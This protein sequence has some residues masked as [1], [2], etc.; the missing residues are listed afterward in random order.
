[1]VDIAEK[2]IS[3]LDQEL[4]EVWKKNAVKLVDALD[5]GFKKLDFG[6]TPLEEIKK[7]Q[8]LINQVNTPK[9]K[10]NRENLLK[11]IREINKALTELQQNK[12]L[13][14]VQ[15]NNFLFQAMHAFKS[16]SHANRLNL[17]LINDYL[18]YAQ[19]FINPADKPGEL[20]GDLGFIPDFVIKKGAKFG[21]KQIEEIFDTHVGSFLVHQ[22]DSMPRVKIEVILDKPKQISPSF[23][24]NQLGKEQYALLQEKRKISEAK[25]V[26]EF[27]TE[28]IYGFAFEL[29]YSQV[30]TY[31]DT[32]HYIEQ[33]AN[34]QKPP[35]MIAAK[36]TALL[37]HYGIEAIST[38]EGKKF[39][40]D[41]SK[42][43]GF[44]SAE[45]LYKNY[46]ELSDENNQSAFD[47]LTEAKK[48]F[49]DLGLQPEL[50]R[51][52][53]PINLIK[54][55]YETEY[56]RIQKNKKNNTFYSNNATY[57]AGINYMVTDFAMA[58]DGV[59]KV[60]NIGAI[61]LK[62]EIAPKFGA[63]EEQGYLAGFAVGVAKYML[64]NDYID[65]NARLGLNG[66]GVILEQRVGDPRKQAKEELFNLMVEKNLKKRSI[67]EKELNNFLIKRTPSDQLVEFYFQKISDPDP[68][69]EVYKD[70]YEA[71]FTMKAL[72]N[73]QGKS[74]LALKNESKN[75][76]T[77]LSKLNEMK[78]DHQKEQEK[79]E[80]QKKAFLKKEGSFW[81]KITRVIDVV[82][83]F[84][85][86]Q[87]KSSKNRKEQEL[88]FK[89]QEE[90][91]KLSAKEL[92]LRIEALEKIENITEKQSEI[93]NKATLESPDDILK[94][95]E[96][97]VEQ[98]KNLLDVYEHRYEVASDS[99]KDLN[100]LKHDF[101]VNAFVKHDF[102]YLD[103]K[104]DFQEKY[105]AL[106]NDILLNKQVILNTKSKYDFD[107]MTQLVDITAKLESLQ[108][109]FNPVIMGLP[110]KYQ[111]FYAEKINDFSKTIN[112][113]KDKLHQAKQER[114]L[115]VH[116]H[117]TKQWLQTNNILKL[118]ALLEE[119]PNELDADYIQ[120][121]DS[122]L[123]EKIFKK[124]KAESQS[125]SFEKINTLNEMMSQLHFVSR[126]VQLYSELKF[127][128]DHLLNQ[129]NLANIQAGF[130]QHRKYLINSTEYILNSSKKLIESQLAS[131]QLK[132]S[133]GSWLFNPFG[134]WVEKQQVASSEAAISSYEEIVTSS[135]VRNRTAIQDF[136]DNQLPQYNQKPLDD[137]EADLE[138]FS[139][140]LIQLQAMTRDNMSQ[141]IIAELDKIIVLYQDL[142]TK[143]ISLQSTYYEKLLESSNQVSMPL[144]SQALVSAAKEGNISVLKKIL[145]HAKENTFPQVIILQALQQTIDNHNID[146]TLLILMNCEVNLD[147]KITK[148]LLAQI[149][150][151]NTSISSCK[152]GVAQL[153]FDNDG[154]VLSQLHRAY[155][156]QEMSLERLKA[157]ASNNKPDKI[158]LN[159]IMMK[160][161]RMAAL[162]EKIVSVLLSN[163][164]IENSSRIENQIKVWD[165][166]INKA[167]KEFS[168]L[169]IAEIQK[170]L[171][172]QDPQF[173]S[174]LPPE[175]NSASILE[176]DSIVEPEFKPSH[177]GAV[178]PIIQPEVIQ[179]NHKEKYFIFKEKLMEHVKE[180]NGNVS[181]FILL[182][183]KFSEAN[184]LAPIELQSDYNNTIAK[185]IERLIKRS[186]IDSFNVM[187][188]FISESTQKTEMIQFA[189][190]Q[191]IQL[192]K[193]N[194]LKILMQKQID[195]MGN[196]Q[197]LGNQI[198]TDLHTIYLE[199]EQGGKD[200]KHVALPKMVVLFL[201]QLPLEYNDK[202]QNLVR[203]AVKNDRASSNYPVKA[204]LW[205]SWVADSDKP[206]LEQYREVYLFSQK[207]IESLVK[208]SNLGLTSPIEAYSLDEI[209][210]L[211]EK[212]N[213][214]DHNLK[215]FNQVLDSFKEG[216]LG[217]LDKT[218]KAKIQS[219]E[220]ADRDPWD[221]ELAIALKEKLAQVKS[222]LNDANKELQKYHQQSAALQDSPTG[223]VLFRFN[224]Q[225]S[226]EGAKK[227]KTLENKSKKKF[228]P[229][230]G[231]F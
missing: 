159:N 221:Q 180:E 188:D 4:Y 103:K 111:E 136:I 170:Q 88:Y 11:I 223:E 60:R 156:L 227:E 117:N 226:S 154:P 81:G 138:L 98:L 199:K 206:L 179:E 8:E 218:I 195:F 211:Q 101:Y 202:L 209:M 201:P 139:D 32:L 191:A 115:E 96:K 2:G 16:L 76:A 75:L 64:N 67:R 45:D 220:R 173:E 171:M 92:D 34:K 74:D 141:A 137:L 17:M 49:C 166:E 145:E 73:V 78:D 210:H 3:K 128:L 53:D 61:A 86:I 204:G 90:I 149:D 192:G 213:F 225:P 87:T 107:Q 77:K 9:V 66:H 197:Q 222:N 41:V 144:L 56:Q 169:I 15:A 121:Y 174:E 143:L 207:L 125:L 119:R 163:V 28:N 123:K 68:E 20:E 26:K 44:I 133:Y 23:L 69:H 177:P 214:I 116:K 155:L 13:G 57:I 120:K 146:S 82:A 50:T 134:F 190:L 193:V 168:E 52:Q 132:F 93:L 105:L 230:S 70:D 51:E 47:K 99:L 229:S 216:Q 187:L 130:V 31:L 94:S 97:N 22:A 71:V 48:N 228:K 198:L 24:A 212:I 59:R 104:S 106:Q 157:E 118:K 14:E 62:D 84:F 151:Q 110:E 43:L 85:G 122:D 5:T 91:S 181:K 1:M 37:K 164:R 21:A 25:D 162:K 189:V 108:S 175:K 100:Y 203:A 158:S 178:T 95:Y 46:S 142:N 58:V 184:Q 219:P 160:Q 186:E 65:V 7:I 55:T 72:L 217:Y 89:K 39:L 185:I 80:V 38:V 176:I 113:Q 114:L 152:K 148:D 54:E 12:D 167:D 194:V 153:I 33:I 83:G 231:K 140:K 161:N 112:D 27:L 129:E 124:I 208:D 102:L 10:D 35:E 79:L 18:K 183:S 172:S 40:N 182:L 205:Q 19:A 224:K 109:V 29:Y 131:D 147:A 42:K 30:A 165:N 215:N 127:N 6:N 196:N 36:R 150:V 200:M 135:L 63:P 126:D